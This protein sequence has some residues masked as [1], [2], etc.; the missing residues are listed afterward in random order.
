MSKQARVAIVHDY[1]NQYGG[2]ERV[3]EAL[4]EIW[5]EAPIYT[6]VYDQKLLSSL[7]FKVN[8]KNVITSFMQK[9]PLRKALPRYY[10]TLIYP[11]AFQSFDFSD[12]DVVIS[13]SSYAAKY[14]KKPQGAIHIGYC[15]T[16]P[17]FL[18][19]Y[20]Q[21]TNVSAMNLFERLAASIWHG[22][23]KN[24]DFKYAQKVDY[25]IANSK[26]V[27]E[28][29][30]KNYGRESEVIYP[31]VD[32]KRFSFAR[33]H[34]ASALG[35]Y[36]LV[37]SR[38]G[39][40]KRVNIVV[41]AF[42]QLGLPLKVVGT[43]PQFENLKK[44]AKSNVEL[45]GRLTD[46]KITELYLG[47]QAFIFPTE[48]DFG[49]TPVEAMAAGK[50]VL[51]YRAGGVVESLLPGVTGEFFSPQ[52]PSAL[53]GAVKKFRSERYDPKKIKTQAK[54]FSKEVFKERMKEF[55]SNIIQKEQQL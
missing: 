9:L 35:R 27:Q 46:Q 22:Y 12:F 33:S 20:D 3:V 19:G 50:S 36:Y 45:L 28:R 38:M 31:P 37:V 8:P 42:N 25:F 44:V 47:C 55:V 34:L 41:E 7:G 4:H 53:I 54:R 1:L 16:P 30:K 2:A 15:H 17:R 10:F 51:A 14:I 29:V 48:E 13:S 24:L 43:G 23:L 18:W 32:I 26:T 49:I 6:S 40:Y 39:E 11:F 5:P 21:E 52:T